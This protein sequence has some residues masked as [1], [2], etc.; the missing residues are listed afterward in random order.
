VNP[1]RLAGAGAACVPCPDFASYTLAFAF[2][3]RKV[4]EHFS[5]GSRKALGW[6]APKTIR[7]V[8]LATVVDGLDWPAGPCRPWLLFR[9]RATRGQR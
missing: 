9:R 8:D 4:M 7:L 6:S 5:Q 3:L 1:P 2:Q